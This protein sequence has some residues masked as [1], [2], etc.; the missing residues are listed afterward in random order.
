M[1]GPLVNF[2]PLR[3]RFTGDRSFE[4]WLGDVRRVV[5]ETSANITLAASQRMRLLRPRGV[6]MPDINARF[7]AWSAAGPTR[8]GAVELEPL[9]STAPGDGLFRIEL[10]HPDETDRCRLD[11]NPQLHEPHAVRTFV[12]RSRAF[13]AAVC[14]EPRRSLRDIHGAIALL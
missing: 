9:A 11:F 3:L 7:V 14:A 8:L 12:A 13:A 5:L 2:A 10:E 6:P 4:N 1:I